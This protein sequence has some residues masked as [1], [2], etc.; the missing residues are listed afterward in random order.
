M[1]GRGFSSD[2]HSRVWGGPAQQELEEDLQANAGKSFRRRP[3][4][5]SIYGLREALAVR[6][7]RQDLARRALGRIYSGDV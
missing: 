3:A 6:G 5:E 2:L 7:L 1:K 4:G